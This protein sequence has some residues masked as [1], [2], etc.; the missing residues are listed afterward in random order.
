MITGLSHKFKL[1]EGKFTLTSGVPKSVENLNFFMSFIGWFRLYA[2][3]YVPDVMWMLQKPN[4]AISTNKVLL[5]GKL[6]TTI[7]E[8]LKDINL[9]RIDFGFV[10]RKEVSLT[11]E[12][13]TYDEPTESIF[14]ATIISL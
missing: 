8:Y 13:S 12:Y 6:T 2:E 11:V 3:D 5:L 9:L 10:S 4:T 7:I 14:S 1:T